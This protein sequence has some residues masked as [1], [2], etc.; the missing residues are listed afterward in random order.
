MPKQT[1]NGWKIEIF[2][3]WILEA[4]N[5]H[6][7]THALRRVNSCI[8]IYAYELQEPLSVMPFNTETH[9]HTHTRTFQHTSAAQC[10]WWFSRFLRCK[11][12]RVPRV[13]DEKKKK[14][15]IWGFCQCISLLLLTLESTSGRPASLSI[16]NIFVLR[17]ISLRKI[18]IS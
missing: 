11:N 8:C 13:C 6:T 14:R 16:S 10:R 12:G 3:N 18:I 2:F 7:C 1:R 17:S 5:T 15:S 9:T 4:D